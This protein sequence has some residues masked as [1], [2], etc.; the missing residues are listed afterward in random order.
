MPRACPS[1]VGK[2]NDYA[3]LQE[4]NGLIRDFAELGY[5][6]CFYQLAGESIDFATLS[7]LLDELQNAGY[8]AQVSFAPNYH[9]TDNAQTGFIHIQWKG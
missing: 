2:K 7:F 1:A 3:I 5:G 6:Q 8:E 4:I 9:R